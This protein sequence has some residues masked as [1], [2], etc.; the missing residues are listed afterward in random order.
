MPRNRGPNQFIG[1]NRHRVSASDLK[2]EL[3]ERDRR[4]L[5]DNKI[6]AEKYLGDPSPDRSALSHHPSGKTSV[7]NFNVRSGR[8]ITQTAASQSTMPTTKT[9]A[10]P[11]LGHI[12]R[13]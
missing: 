4:Q 8:N 13:A 11:A 1:L 2:V 5:A 3:E 6:D 9:N 12:S 10:I 7:K